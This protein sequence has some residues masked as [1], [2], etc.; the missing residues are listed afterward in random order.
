MNCKSSRDEF[1]G[2]ILA[3]GV[4]SRLRPM[5]NTKP[6]CLV[7]TSGKP[8]LQYQIDAY[9]KAGV[10]ELIIVVGYESLSVKQFCKHIKDLKITIVE[11]NDYENTNNMYSFYL[12]KDY[13][14]N[15]PFILNNADLSI[16]LSIVER[17]IDFNKPSAVV[18]DSSQFNHESMK[19]SLNEKKLI[20]D[21]SKDIPQQLSSGCSIDFYKF[22]KEDSKI[23]IKEVIN[24]IEHEKN[25]RDWTEIALQRLFKSQLLKFSMCDI[26]GCD[27]VEID[28]YNDLAISDRKFSKFD[29]IFETIKT[30]FLDLD[31]TVYVGTKKIPGVVEAINRIMQQGKE[32]FFLSNNSSKN[33]SDY[34]DRLKTMGITA[35]PEQIII[36]T[37]GVIDYLKSIRVEQ[38]HILGTNSLKKI[39]LDEGFQIDSISP[40]Y[41]IVGYD[42]ELSYGKLVTACKY[43]NAG[44]DIIATHCDVSCPSENG[45]IPDVGAFLEMIKSTT[46]KSPIKVFG[47][48]TSNMILPTIRKTGI[49]PKQILFVGD[50]LHTDILMAKDVGSYGLLVLSGDTTRDKLENSL[51]QPDF[52]LNSLAEI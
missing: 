52:V 22:S 9:R 25:L 51:I 50:R 49:D 3:A 39:F 12:T 18:V 36:S 11:N 32:V 31:G 28:N 1:I 34:V 40:E 44:V 24:I 23:F 8:I 43:I 6:K 15:R 13:L 26:A 20:C 46:G 30:V 14:T 19:I 45:P 42:T 27:W 10:K 21:I 17:L 47:K 5:T 2:V 37:D 33:K 29:N 4:G 48:P 41:V 38:V 16:D 35:K 7:K